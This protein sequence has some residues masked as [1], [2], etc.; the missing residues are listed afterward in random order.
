MNHTAPAR[1]AAR[2][3]TRLLLASLALLIAAVVGSLGY[4][5]VSSSATSFG[6]VLR[7]DHH[8]ALGEDDGVVPD[9]ATPFDVGIPAVAN[10][11]QG[12]LDALRRA[13]TAAADDGVEVYVNSGW[14]SPRY[15]KH[16]FGEAVS[17]HGSREA[18]ARWVASSNTS[19]HVA[20]E[21]VDLGHS[22]AEA[23]L[24]EHGAG[25]GLCQIYRN[26]PWHYELRPEAVD[27]GC[28]SMYVD[29]TH[30]PRMQQ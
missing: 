4:P 10:L 20:G 28:P 14:R 24:S 5:S 8:G 16:L 21:A 30:D 7:G 1:G 19:A 23:W 29:P 15:Q 26:E 13:A 6:E 2:L 25:Y 11:D 22:D 18:A 9:G 17:E 12:L 3:P 27:H